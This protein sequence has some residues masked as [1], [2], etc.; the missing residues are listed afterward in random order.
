MSV[1]PVPPN[2]KSLEFLAGGG[3]I[4][5]LLRAADWS[6]TELGAPDHW[7]QALKTVVRLMLS[8]NHPM[9]VFWGSKHIC[10]YNDAYRASIGPEKH[11][12]M[13]GSPGRTMWPEIWD[14]IGPQIDHVM[15]GQGAT[16]H[17]DQLVPIVRNGKLED[18][19]WTYSYSPIDHDGGVG[20]VL[21][22]CTETTSRVL[23]SL[24]AGHELQSIKDLLQ[25]SPSFACFLEGPD[26]RFTF[27]NNACRRIAGDRDL[28]GHAVADVLPEASD[29]GFVELLDRVFANGETHLGKSERHVLNSPI[30]G[31]SQEFF[32]DYIYT[33]IFDRA[34]AVSGVFVNGFDV[35]EHRRTVDALRESE[36]RY[37]SIVDSQAEMVCRFEPAGRI[38]FANAAYARMTNSNVETLEGSEFWAFIPEDDRPHVRAM[39]DRMTPDQPEVTITNRILN[40]NGERWTEWTNRALR[41]DH[42]GHVV[43]AQSTGID[44][45]ERRQAEAH[46]TLLLD[47]LNHRVKNTLNVVQ[48]IAQLSF[49]S[50]DDL[51]SQ[52]ADFN[53]R[54]AALAAAHAALT[55]AQW[56]HTNLR[57]IASAT[58]A[59]CLGQ[60]DRISV[61]GPDVLLDP[62]A[63]VALT[64][65]LHELTTNAVKYGALTSEHGAVSIF[66]TTSTDV[67]GHRLRLIWI[68]SGGP[69]VSA[70]SRRGFGSTL[71]E[72]ALSH[73][74]GGEAALEFASTG[75]V[76]KI[77]VPLVSGGRS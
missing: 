29:H 45:T 5:A 15:A 8:T 55:Q 20:G 75:V 72:R 7:P 39:L 49:K 67:Q 14:I 61:R 54:L 4:G 59:A 36:A 57:Q 41:F 70:P 76:C 63:A 31:E 51:T 44:I 74:L 10:L 26:H 47:E 69:A 3:E 58:I 73:E 43:E 21:V 68:E 23:S 35:T 38:L 77:D 25:Q 24:R 6:T 60:D 42:L 56:Q 65:A 2:S 34:G 19:Y 64:L 22:L 53:G 27:A 32:L 37:R 46:R 50:T 9:F 52:R 71:I 48:A 18:V 62:K 11:P 1:M 30:T 16:W 66:W 12:S 28:L 33:P 13:I 40:A 17:E